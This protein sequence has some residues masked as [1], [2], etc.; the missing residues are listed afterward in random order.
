M[1]VDLDFA[2][3]F[4]DGRGWDAEGFGT[5][6]VH[7]GVGEEE[8]VARVVDLVGEIAELAACKGGLDQEDTVVLLME[9]GVDGEAACE[10]VLQD[11]YAE[12]GWELVPLVEARL[13]GFSRFHFCDFA[14]FGSVGFFPSSLLLG[15]RRS[16]CRLLVC[17]FVSGWQHGDELPGCDA[18]GRKW[19]RQPSCDAGGHNG[20]ILF[21]TRGSVSDGVRDQ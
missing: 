11:H 6:G 13:N 4:A 16:S 9:T 1:D 8:C 20:E 7:F 10:V 19:G 21:I 2:Q 17:D 18:V 14:A 3:E 5:G 15:Q 12:L